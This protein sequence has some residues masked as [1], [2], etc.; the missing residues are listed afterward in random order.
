MT[1]AQWN[2]AEASTGLD[3]WARETKA[4]ARIAASIALTP[5][6]PE[7]LRVVDRRTGEVE[8]EATVA[9]VTAALLTGRE[10]GM[11]PMAALRSIDVVHGTPALRAVAL[12]ALV[13]N[14]GH[15]LWLV[16]STTTRCVM[17]GQ[18]L[19]S[20]HV[21]EVTWTMDRARGLGIAGRDQW[22][23]QP[24]AM[25]V[26]RATGEISRIVAP[27]A[28]LGLPYLVEEIGDDGGDESTPEA[29]SKPARKRTV[30]RA[31]VEAPSPPVAPVQDGDRADEPPPPDHQPE[32]EPPPVSEAQL[33]ALHSALSFRGIDDRDER[34]A[35]VIGV[36]GRDVVSSK[37]LTMSEASTVLD[38]LARTEFDD[39]PPPPPAAPEPE[40]PEADE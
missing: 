31:L 34:L 10:L 16:E 40:P 2:P 8:V 33:K 24:I 25:L 5:F 30:R 35:Y 32:P 7:S 21:Q 4:A 19:G 18:R 37:D 14:R 15:D 39:E 12:R 36:I 26:A 38:H 29:E 11:S 9:I 3:A 23:R 1:V 28:L 6:V 20:A 17:R 22:R 13:L 27:E